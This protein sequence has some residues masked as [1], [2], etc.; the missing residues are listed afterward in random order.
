M[1]AEEYIQID[2]VVDT[3]DSG[4]SDEKIIEEVL[5]DTGVELKN[6]NIDSNMLLPSEAQENYASRLKIIRD[7][8][9]LFDLDDIR[10]ETALKEII[11]EREALRALMLIKEGEI[12]N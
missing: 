5:K 2:L 3:Y 9:V 11:E 10:L 8:S 1:N 4:Q 12:R 7:T 6:L